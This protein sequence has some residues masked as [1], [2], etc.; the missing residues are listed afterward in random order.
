MSKPVVSL[1]TSES[2]IV[3]PSL[4][5]EVGTRNRSGM[6]ARR[7]A[8]PVLSAAVQKTPEPSWR[9]DKKAMR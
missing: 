9:S 1:K 2:N 5:Q 7:S 4:D 6:E 3:C 8:R